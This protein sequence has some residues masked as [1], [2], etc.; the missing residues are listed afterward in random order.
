MKSRLLRLTFATASIALGPVAFIPTTA[1][2]VVPSSASAVNTD[3]SGLAMEGY[4]P[5]AYFADGAPA[6]GNPRFS[7]VLNGATYRFANQKHLEQFKAN[8]SAYLPQFGGFCAMG[9][10]F[11]QKVNGDP[12]VWRVVDKK[13]YL[14]NSPVVGKLWNKDVPGNISRADEK[15]PEIKD[16][17]PEDLK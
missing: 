7:Y 5:V 10:S 14:N 6:Q 16:R 1:F 9:T 13:L 15:W 11:G 17:A 3:A 12:K 8:P 4:D 2:A